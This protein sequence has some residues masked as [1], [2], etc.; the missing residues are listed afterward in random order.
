MTNEPPMQELP[1]YLCHKKVRALK[2]GD[3]EIFEG[4]VAIIVPENTNY[5][6]FTTEQGWASRYKGSRSDPGYYVVYD[7]G[8]TSWSPT[9]AFESG[10]SL[11]S[12]ASPLDAIKAAFAK[13]DDYAWTWQCNLAMIAFDEGVSHQASNER[14]AGFI[15]NAF[16][17]DIKAVDQWKD[18]QEYW[19]N[20][21]KPTSIEVVAFDCFGTVFDMSGVSRDEINAYVAHVKKA[22]FTPYEFPQSWW[23]LKLHHDAAE[24]VRMLQEAGYKCV[25]LSN[26]SAHL[27]NHVSLAG[28][29]LWDKVIDLVKHKA[30]KP[31]NLDAYRS[32][33]KETG[34][35]PEQ[36]L[37]V[38]ANPTFGD[39][40][41]S[42]AIGMQCQVIRH[43]YPETII[44]LAKM[45]PQKEPR[46]SS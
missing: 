41:S 45:M 1:V 6:S 33:E 38:T 30:Y 17:F 8:Y 44:D 15:K 26:G 3:I 27:L 46:S 21:K 32:V 18:M 24:G 29:I 5:P 43:G 42:T 36:T 11:A 20:F 25:T 2:I 4:Q 40:E 16:D 10:Y 28:G 9:E 14:A 7:D 39:V 37:M 31:D 23:N 34:F 12:D 22:D 19:K 35:K 13:D